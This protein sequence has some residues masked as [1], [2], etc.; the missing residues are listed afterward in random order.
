MTDFF[1][2]TSNKNKTK[3]SN[4]KEIKLN[5]TWVYSAKSKKKKK[6]VI[7]NT[8]PQEQTIFQVRN[9]L[10]NERD[11]QKKEERWSKKQLLH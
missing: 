9:L 2:Q 5:L 11:T 4:Q 8:A 10:A 3:Q 1:Q 6:D 7:Q